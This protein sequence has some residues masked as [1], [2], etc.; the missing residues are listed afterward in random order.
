M[1]EF[2]TALFYTL[3][4]LFFIKSITFFDKLG[5]VEHK[6]MLPDNTNNNRGTTQPTSRRT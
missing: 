1:K 4:G 3:L 6:N 5:I 2:L